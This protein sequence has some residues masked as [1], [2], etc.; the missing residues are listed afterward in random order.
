MMH[1]GIL[2]AATGA[3]VW[4]VAAWLVGPRAVWD[5]PLFWTVGVAL[6]ALTAFLAGLECPRGRFLWGMTTVGLLPLAWAAARLRPV[7]LGAALVTTLLCG[8]ALTLCAWAGAWTSRFATR[9][10][11]V[12]RR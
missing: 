7:E 12:S 5:S 2:T 10:R 1:T 4:G 3:I 9:R 6:L 11:D 8:G